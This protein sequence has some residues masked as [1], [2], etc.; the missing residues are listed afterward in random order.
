MDTITW[1]IAANV[2]VWLGIGGYVLFIARG[3]RALQQRLQMK[4]MLHHD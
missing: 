4:E 1:L 2:V 3:Q